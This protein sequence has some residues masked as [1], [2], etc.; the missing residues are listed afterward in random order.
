[1]E[2]Q[3]LLTS[4]VKQSQCIWLS[5]N[6]DRNSIIV[7]DLEQKRCKL[8]DLKL[9]LHP[10]DGDIYVVLQHRYTSKILRRATAHKTTIS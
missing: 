3:P 9:S 8:S 7:K 5:T 4:C 10:E 2:E 1:M 6:H